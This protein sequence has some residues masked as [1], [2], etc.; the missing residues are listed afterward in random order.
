MD[1]RFTINYFF[2]LLVE[3]ENASG[4]TWD[5]IKQALN[6]KKA[7]LQKKKDGW[8]EWTP[9]KS[10]ANTSWSYRALRRS[11][12]GPTLAYLRGRNDKRPY[13]K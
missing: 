5:Q 2:I 7:E 9:S 1:Y 4:S 12:V 13:R 11:A 8:D 6:E 3:N 10:T